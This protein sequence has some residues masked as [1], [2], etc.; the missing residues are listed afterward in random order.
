MPI[1]DFVR[2]TT[3]DVLLPADIND[4]Q[5]AVETISDTYELEARAYS[6]PF[7]DARPNPVLGDLNLSTDGGWAEVFDGSA[8]VP[9]GPA[10]P[11]YR[12][13]LSSA[14]TWDNQGTS[15][16]DNKTGLRMKS[17]GA[18]TGCRVLWKTKAFPAP[19]TVQAVM[20]R[21]GAINSSGFSGIA[22]RDSSGKLMTCAMSQAGSFLVDKWTNA[23]TFS[24]N[25]KTDGLG[26]GMT[27][28]TWWI[29]IWDNGTNIGFDYSSDYGFTWTNRYTEGRTAFFASGPTQIA[30]VVNDTGNQ[31]QTGW[32]LS[33]IE[34]SGGQ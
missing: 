11:L 33:F 32:F 34:I 28:G 14:L 8:W 4:L 6:R 30:F 31:A 1:Y 13:P 26:L 23:T 29:R 5:S 22:F 2:K 15:T 18:S 17:P 3:G 19:Y 10:F 9:Y 21:N 20:A 7:G 27:F 16:V 25:A 12:P 24:A